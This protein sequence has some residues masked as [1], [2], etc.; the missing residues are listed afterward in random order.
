MRPTKDIFPFNI[1]LYSEVQNSIHVYDNNYGYTGTTL[2]SRIFVTD[3]QK[4]SPN[5]KY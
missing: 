1:F 4:K 5:P 2:L 3:T